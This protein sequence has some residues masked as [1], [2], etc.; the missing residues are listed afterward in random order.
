MS[1][2]ILVTY[3][4]KHGSTREVA[5]SVAQTLTEQ[6]LEVETLPAMRVDDLGRYTGVV[7]GGAL[8]M[9]RW[10]P[11]AVEFLEQH[12]HEL[13]TLPVAVF[14]MGP[15]TMEEHD[16]EGSRAQLVK[17]LARV[18]EAEPFALAVFGGVIDPKTLRFPLSRLPASDARDWSAIR[19]W[20]T[21]I[22]E[23]FAYGKAASTPRDHRRELQQTP[24]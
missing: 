23:V 8:Y 11:A 7:V 17:A 16:V 14:G 15:R 2:T 24:R 19:A 18:P 22:A 5:E 4:T 21:E 1:G 3:G 10:H 12:R 20:A 6:G 13:A 9:G